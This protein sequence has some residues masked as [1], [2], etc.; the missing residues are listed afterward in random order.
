VEDEHDRSL[1]GELGERDVLPVLPVDQ[2][3][4]EIRRLLALGDVVGRAH[5]DD[6]ELQVH[7]RSLLGGRGLGRR[8]RW[9]VAVGGL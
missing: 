8:R 4:D 1:R 2:R 7:L 9:L 5:V 6:V 3:A